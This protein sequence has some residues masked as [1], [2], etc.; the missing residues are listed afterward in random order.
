MTIDIPDSFKTV[1]QPVTL[2]FLFG[3]DMTFSAQDS[4]GAFSGWS[5]D[6][7]KIAGT[8]GQ[9]NDVRFFDDMSAGAS[10][11]TTVAPDRDVGTS[12]VCARSPID[13]LLSLDQR[14]RSHRGSAQARLSTPRSALMD[15]QGVHPNLAP[16]P[17][18]PVRQLEQSPS[19]IPDPG[20]SGSPARTTKRPGRPED[21]IGLAMGGGNPERIEARRL[22][23]VEQPG[24]QS[25]Q[26]GRR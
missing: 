13:V 22:P 23:S 3:S 25:V 24:F 17:E 16:P 6:D 12:R 14:L 7:V 18:A 5:L 1:T 10:Q 2:Q 26:H 20:R 8:G 19:T 21:V 11:W 9:Q 4:S 15:L